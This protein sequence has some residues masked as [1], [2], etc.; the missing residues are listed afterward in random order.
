[1]RLQKIMLGGWGRGRSSQAGGG[2]DESALSL[3]DALASESPTLVEELLRMG[4]RPRTVLEG[5]VHV[6]AD[7]PGGLCP[8]PLHRCWQRLSDALT[9]QQAG[10]AGSAGDDPGDGPAGDDPAP[11]QQAFAG[12]VQ[13]GASLDTPSADSDASVASLVES[14]ATQQ[15]DAAASIV[16][17]IEELRTAAEQAGHKLLTAAEQNDK[18]RLAQLLWDQ[19]EAGAASLG[20]TRADV[21]FRDG[22]GL[23][24]LHWALVRGNARA[25]RILLRNGADLQLQD[26]WGLAPLHAPFAPAAAVAAAARGARAGDRGMH[27]LAHEPKLEPMR[28]HSVLEILTQELSTSVDTLD[29]FGGGT[30][31]H[32]A[33]QD[34]VPET[35]QGLRWNG[36]SSTVQDVQGK[37]AIER[38]VREPEMLSALDD[39]PRLVT[40]PPRPDGSFEDDETEQTEHSQRR[41]VSFPRPQVRVADEK[42]PASGGDETGSKAVDSAR[43]ALF[44]GASQSAPPPIDDTA[45]SNT[46]EEEEE[47]ADDGSGSDIFDGLDGVTG[48]PWDDLAGE[49]QAAA[50]ILGWD[51]ESQWVDQA[52]VSIRVLDKEF[53]QLSAEEQNACEELEINEDDWDDMELLRSPQQP[54]HS[55]PEPEP[56]PE[57][58][59]EPAR[60]TAPAGEAP[61]L[62]GRGGARLLSSVAL[63]QYRAHAVDEVCSLLNASQHV[64]VGLLSQHDWD[65]GALLRLS[66]APLALNSIQS[67]AAC[68]L[69]L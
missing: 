37:T 40:E 27:P 26:N 65:V 32:Y 57:P 44:G 4:A 41:C 5:A 11:L 55:Q 35:V 12:L 9:A 21:S 3:C 52:Q 1:M 28:L 2:G 7:C 50:R 66:S 61:D 10:S 31:L 15:V 46:S 67:Q 34:G 16:A 8:G 49:Q 53:H 20:A 48:L 64:A 59:L 17:L 58:E 38:A 6:C 68:H 14:F 18:V 51:G 25:V 39:E 54:A 45:S 29:E 43:N 56:E 23:T 22:A 19:Q 60:G 36:A 42:E 69:H 63:A 33:V 24:A 62:R 47:E 30:L 13:A